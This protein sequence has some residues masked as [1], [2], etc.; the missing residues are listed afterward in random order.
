MKSNDIITLTA[1]LTALTQLDQP[2]PKKVKLELNSIGATLAK[3]PNDIGNLDAIAESYQPL[4]AI[5]QKE[6][7]ILNNNIRERNNLTPPPLS[8]DPSAELTNAASNTFSS[9]NPYLNAKED[10]KLKLLLQRVQEFITG[11][12]NG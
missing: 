2:L 11:K 10:L 8:S 4:D 5:Y 7:T 6:L 1:F 3:D 9:D 12:K